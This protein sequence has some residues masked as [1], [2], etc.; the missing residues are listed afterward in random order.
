[1]NVSMLFAE[2][3]CRSMARVRLTF[4]MFSQRWTAWA[5]VVG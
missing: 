2:V 4:G 1:M 5:M 3:K